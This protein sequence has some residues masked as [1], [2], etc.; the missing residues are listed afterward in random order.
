MEANYF[1]ILYWFAIHQKTLESP[2]DCKE[3][4]PVHPKG[5]KS[6]I[7]IGRADAKA[8]TPILWSPDAKNWVT[9]KDSD[10][11][12]DW[13]Q[14]EKLRWLDGITDSMDWV[15]ASSG[16]WWWTGKPGVL[17]SMGW[18]SVRHYWTT[19]LS[20]LIYRYLLLLIPSTRISFHLSYLFR[21]YQFYTTYYLI[22]VLFKALSFWK[23]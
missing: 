3:I 18:Q 14:K 5:D 2:L 4:Q 7:F 10:A 23:S 19:E 15:W 22:Y 21:A 9:G 20:W 17:Q 8:E 12:K 13:R 11:G 6:W 16:Y 1:T